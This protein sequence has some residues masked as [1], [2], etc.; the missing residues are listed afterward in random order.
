MV[1]LPT[2]ISKPNVGNICI[3]TWILW[4]METITVFHFSFLHP[5]RFAWISS[6]STVSVFSSP[7]LPEKK[8][9]ATIETHQTLGSGKVRRFSPT[10]HGKPLKT[11]QKKMVLENQPVFFQENLTSKLF[12]KRTVNRRKATREHGFT[13]KGNVEFAPQKGC[14]P[15]NFP[16][17]FLAAS[18]SYQLQVIQAANLRRQRWYSKHYK[19][20]YSP[21]LGLCKGNPN[22]K[23]AL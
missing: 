5:R 16:C 8:H 2:F 18:L 13:R 17:G 7:I 12:G 3:H 6:E 14:Q 21:L 15:T 11:N 20:L 23:T 9:W 22:P 19:A 10:T 1:Y 4:D